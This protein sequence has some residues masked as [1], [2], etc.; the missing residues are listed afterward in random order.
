MA[1]S[2]IAHK[3]E[4]TDT[5]P[6]SAAINFVKRQANPKSRQRLTA[7]DASAQPPRNGQPDTEDSDD[8]S[9]V[10][11]NQRKMKPVYQ[12]FSTRLR[13]DLKRRLKRLSH[14]R[15]DIGHETQSVTRFVEE[16]LLAWLEHQEEPPTA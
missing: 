15:E 10:R 3:T 4:E 14:Y 8:T 12:P 1:K 5:M 6:P 9:N 7:D 13:L 2:Q 11:S 16:A